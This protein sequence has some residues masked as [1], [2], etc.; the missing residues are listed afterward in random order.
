MGSHYQ[1]SV[2]TRERAQ[3]LAEE[4]ESSTPA[5]RLRHPRR[6]SWWPPTVARA[7]SRVRSLR[8]PKPGTAFH[9]FND[10]LALFH[11]V[12]N[13]LD[14]W[15]Q[16]WREARC[17]Q[18]VAHGRSGHLGEFENLFTRWI[19]REQDVL[20][21]G[22]GPGQLLAA[23]NARGY[24]GV[25]IDY[26]P[27]VVALAQRLMPDLEIRQ[28]NVLSLDFPTGSFG[29]Y[30]SVGVIEHLVEGPAAVLA[31]ARRVLSPRGVALISV[32]Y[33]NPYRQRH[34][35]RLPRGVPPPEGLAFHQYYFS[36]EELR[37]LLESAGFRVAEFFPYGAEAFLSREHPFFV[38]FWRSGACRGPIRRFLRH[39]MAHAPLAFRMHYGHM[40]MAVCLPD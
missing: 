23:L 15:R 2:S 3:G 6:L 14:Y 24:R 31:E 33:L 25:G 37:N 20:E 21:A 26:E 7:V 19:P 12:D 8:D 32:P 10:R 16:Y 34:L 39:W 1:A 36:R 30:L 22:C 38:S 40:V 18:L 27:E 4:A 29:C 11:Q 5:R 13:H 17:S 28:G 35:E 9:R